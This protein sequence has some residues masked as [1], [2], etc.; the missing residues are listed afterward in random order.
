MSG[1]QGLE[2]P[3]RHINLSIALPDVL[4]VPP[5]V[6]WRL[7]TDAVTVVAAGLCR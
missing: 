3:D 2:C 5:R 4:T 1:R 6:Q 7:G